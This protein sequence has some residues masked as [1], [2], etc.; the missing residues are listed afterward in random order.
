MDLILGAHS[1]NSGPMFDFSGERPVLLQRLVSNLGG[2]SGGFSL[3]SGDDAKGGVSGDDSEAKSGPGSDSDSSSE[4][5]DDDDDDDDADKQ[6]EIWY[7]PLHDQEQ[8]Q[9][10]QVRHDYIEMICF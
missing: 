7:G 3:G 1:R 6:S 10:G 4:D 5:S 8:L 2:G 9:V